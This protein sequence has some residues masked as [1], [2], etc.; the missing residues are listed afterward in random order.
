M[1]IIQPLQSLLKNHYLENQN[2]LKRKVMIFFFFFL[3]KKK[4]KKKKKNT[5]NKF[6]FFFKKE[7]FGADL[8]DQPFSETLNVPLF[9][10]KCITH[11]EKNGWHYFFLIFWL[12]KYLPII[13]N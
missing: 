8:T 10:E 6:F 3:K 13:N 5:N 4:K 1:V 9:V 12:N 11:V 2:K 7:I